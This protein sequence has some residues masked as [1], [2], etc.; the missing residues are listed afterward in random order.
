MPDDLESIRDYMEHWDDLSF[1]DRRS[2]VDKLILA[3]NIT[4]EN[5]QIVWKI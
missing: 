5:A 4:K 1:D 2:V 3:V